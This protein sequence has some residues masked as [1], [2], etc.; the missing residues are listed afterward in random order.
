MCA[1]CIECAS[2]PKPSLSLHI[3]GPSYCR[4]TVE[5]RV[6]GHINKF[7]TDT[8]PLP[9]RLYDQRG[10]KA[11]RKSFQFPRCTIHGSGKERLK[12]F[13]NFSSPARRKLHKNS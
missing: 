2:Q 4:L 10:E 13:M 7:L 11:W 1:F 5:R 8:L 6:Q 12:T 9:F 3:K